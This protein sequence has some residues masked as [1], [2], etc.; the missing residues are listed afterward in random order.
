M[1]KSIEYVHDSNGLFVDTTGAD[2]EASARRFEELL[3]AALRDAYPGVPVE[4]SDRT[5]YRTQIWALED[6]EGE[7]INGHV[8]TYEEANQ[9]AKETGS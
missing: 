2:V 8:R 7:D 5:V 6:V 4:I 1:I 3:H 9:E